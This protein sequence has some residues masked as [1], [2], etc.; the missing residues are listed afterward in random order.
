MAEHGLNMWILLLI[1]IISTLILFFAVLWLRRCY[2]YKKKSDGKFSLNPKQP[3]IV[4]DPDKY[5]HPEI[6]EI[7]QTFLNTFR[8]DI[9]KPGVSVDRVRANHQ[10]IN[11]LS[12]VLE[13]RRTKRCE[14]PNSEPVVLNLKDSIT[15][16][17]KFGNYTATF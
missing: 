17:A 8:N 9:M 4:F 7:R 15:T 12:S 16:Y 14:L 11:T 6:S 1:I 5:K 10:R 2:V 13:Y 3:F